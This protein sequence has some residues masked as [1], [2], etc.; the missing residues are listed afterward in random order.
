VSAR[1]RVVHAP[2]ITLDGPAC[3]TYTG[4]GALYAIDDQGRYRPEAVTCK[5]CLW[6]LGVRPGPAENI[7]DLIGSADDRLRSA[8]RHTG[9]A[10]LTEAERVD[11]G[12]RLGRT[13]QLTDN[14]SDALTVVPG[15]DAISDY[16]REQA[17]GEG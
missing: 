14:I 10:D 5:R 4:C 17:G 9:G 11:L 1:Q 8:L 6:R 13:Q 15:T 16:L 12:E 2:G 3:G 7:A